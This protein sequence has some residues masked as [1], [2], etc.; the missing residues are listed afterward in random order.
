M[1]AQRKYPDELRERATRMVIDARKDPATRT[2]AFRRI[3][4]QLGV[5]PERRTWVSRAEIDEGLRPDTTTADADRI[6]ELE[7][8]VR[9]LRPG[10]HDP[11]AGLGFLRSGARPPSR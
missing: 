9:E 4:E 5:N 1:P 11:E 6:T 2:G 8:E 7:R 3:G 10:E